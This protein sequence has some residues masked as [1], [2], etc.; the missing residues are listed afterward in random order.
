M[1]AAGVPL[2]RSTRLAL[3]VKVPIRTSGSVPSV[4]SPISSRAYFRV[5][6]LPVPA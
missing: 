4:D 5:V 2:R 3:P 1:V 6:D